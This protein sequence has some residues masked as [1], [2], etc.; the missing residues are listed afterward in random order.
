[1][2]VS[3]DLLAPVAQTL[4]LRRFEIVVVSSAQTN[5]LE[6]RLK[7]FFDG[8]ELE[9]SAE[10]VSLTELAEGEV[11][12]AVNFVDDEMLIPIMETLVFVG[13]NLEPDDV[14]QVYFQDVESYLDGVRY[15]SA[16]EDDW[17][18]F[19]SGSDNEVRHIFNYEHALEVLMRCSLRRRV[20]SG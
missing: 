10:P 9:P 19:E 13:K 18:K 5:H 17:A 8:R 12:F 15:G 4:T 7:V 11:Y 6:R 16:S 1:M 2:V 20:N 3:A 14:G